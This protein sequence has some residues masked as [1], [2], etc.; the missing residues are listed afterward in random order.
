MFPSVDSAGPESEDNTYTTS[1]S[2]LQPVS[3]SLPVV[4]TSPDQ[5]LPVKEKKL[6]KKKKLSRKKSSTEDPG[7]STDY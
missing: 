1:Q 4:T 6:K 2:Q 3:T 7:D 5:K